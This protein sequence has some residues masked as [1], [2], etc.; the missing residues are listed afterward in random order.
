MSDVPLLKKVIYIERCV[1]KN[2][3]IHCNKFKETDVKDALRKFQDR[4]KN[5]VSFYDPDGT[6]DGVIQDNIWR[7]FNEVFGV[8]DTKDKLKDGDMIG[9]KRICILKKEVGK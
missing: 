8:L 1:K 7:I 9:T 6:W 2:C 4:V 5:E 3:E